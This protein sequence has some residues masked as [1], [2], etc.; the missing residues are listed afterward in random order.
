[1]V[2]VIRN[3][4]M[5]RIHEELLLVGDIVLIEIGMVHKYL[6]DLGNTSRWSDHRSF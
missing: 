2:S 4:Q 6:L 5:S 3:K 1:M